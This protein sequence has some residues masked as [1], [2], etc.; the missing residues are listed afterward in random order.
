MAAMTPEERLA[1][2]RDL[3]VQGRVISD[4]IAELAVGAVEPSPDIRMAASHLGGGKVLIKWET[5]RIDITGWE[6]SRDGKDTTGGGAWGATVSAATREFQFNLL[7]WGET[8]RFTLQPFSLS[9]AVLE[10][11]TIVY[12]MPDAPELP[13]DP[14]GYSPAASRFKWGAPHEISDRFYSPY[15]AR[16]TVPDPAKW[17][18]PGAGGWPGHAGNGRRMRENVFV[19][20]G[21]MTLHGEP[22][23]NT[24]WVRQRLNVKYG[25]WEIRSRSMNVGSVGNLYHVLHLL[26]AKMANGD[27][28]PFPQGGEYD[29][30]EYM[31]PDSQKLSAFTHYPQD[32]GAVQQEYDEKPGVDMT[33]WNWLGVEWTKDH[34]AGFVNGEQWFK[35]SGGAR[36][37]TGD[38]PARKNIQDMPLAAL[39]IQLDAFNPGGLRPAIFEVSDVLFYPV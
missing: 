34:V 31:N 13:T 14:Q 4:E 37:K 3:A 35:R 8:Y 24:G 6:I 29:W 32:P 39:T 25:R 10:P 30:V 12:I 1:K 17:Q 23:G 21:V 5:V 20:D 11:V 22:N 18:V 27:D 36:G 26:W 15:Y 33:K 9:G 19:K 28:H 38:N 2:I 16:A 7:V